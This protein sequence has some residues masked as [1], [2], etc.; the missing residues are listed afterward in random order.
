M[1]Q[2][3]RIGMGFTREGAP[4]TVENMKRDANTKKLFACGAGPAILAVADTKA[5]AAQAGDVRAF[6]LE[7]GDFV[8]INEGIWNDA[9]HGVSGAT[10]YFFLSLEDEESTEYVPIKGGTLVVDA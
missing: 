4:Y 8:V 7:P 6:L 5:D 1:D 3:A 2:A 9:C 10:H